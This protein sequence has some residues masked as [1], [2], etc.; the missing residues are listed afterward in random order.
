MFCINCFHPST[1]V[2]NSRPNKKQP[3]IW[4]R[5][6]C[7]KCQIVFT[8]YERPSL[9]DNKPVSLPDGSRD[10]FNL[11]K[12][13]LSIAS[14]FSHAPKEASYNSLWL[15]QTVEDTLST[16]R[17]V[18]TPEDIEATTHQVLKKFDELAAIQYAAKH[19]LISSTRKRGRPSLREH[20]P[21][22][23]V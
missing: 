17:Q 19:H 10:T 15:A 14:A 4:R 18:I 16:E 23:G 5:R 2:S 9:A 6:T 21:R 8:T 20:E 7:P 3:Q 12:L 11:G 13:I 22:S 1:A